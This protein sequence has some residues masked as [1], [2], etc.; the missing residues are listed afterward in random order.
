[1]WRHAVVRLCGAV[2]LCVR[3]WI[4]AE[5]RLCGAVMQWGDIM[6]SI[7]V[8]WRGYGTLLLQL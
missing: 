4:T 2:L 3:L 7:A 5:V 6:R 8:V 1:M